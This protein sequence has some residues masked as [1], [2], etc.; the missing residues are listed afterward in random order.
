[1]VH[2]LHA[3]VLDRRG[4]GETAAAAQE[5]EEAAAEEDRPARRG[6]L[7]TSSSPAG[8]DIERTQPLA[9]IDEPAEDPEKP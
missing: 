6:G 5:V 1:M 9:A 2:R 8:D 3:D 4:E 7:F